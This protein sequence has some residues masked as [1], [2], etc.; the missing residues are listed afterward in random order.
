LKVTARE[1]YGIRAVVDI[2]INRSQAPIQARDISARQSIP[3]QFLEQV[4]AS[5]RRAGIVR[6]VRGASGGYDL[7][8]PAGQ[9]TVGDVLRALSGPL[10][11]LPQTAGGRSND[12]QSGAEFFWSRLREA[13]E[14]V[15]DGTTVQDLV[16]Y[17]LRWKQVH[18]YMMH[19]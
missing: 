15:A 17:E 8:K 19:I 7:A 3:E 14:D 16:D 18:S 6:S 12:A 9:I 5:L 4:L 11:D 2:A 1:D 13:V 10:P